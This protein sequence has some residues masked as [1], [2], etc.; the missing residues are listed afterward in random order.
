MV[1]FEGN[2]YFFQEHYFVMNWGFFALRSVYQD[3]SFELSKTVFQ[4]FF[5][6]FIIRGFGGFKKLPDM[7]ENVKKKF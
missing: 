6:F 1:I 3:A 2:F 7:K 4:Q 5:K